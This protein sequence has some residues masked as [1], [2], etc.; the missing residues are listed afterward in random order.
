M[1]QTCQTC[2][3]AGMQCL[4]RDRD[5]IEHCPQGTYMPSTNT[6]TRLCVPC[7]AGNSC[8][9]KGT[10]TACAADEYSQLGEIHCH[11]CPVGAQCPNKNG[12]TLCTAGQYSNY[13]AL[14]CSACPLGH[15]CPDIFQQPQ[16]CPPGTYQSSTGQIG[17]LQ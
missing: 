9:Q 8:I 4:F 1:T 17:C 11:K 3:E 10:A 6:A 7:P 5:Y 16:K 12:Y 14:T 13:G 15:F 2:N